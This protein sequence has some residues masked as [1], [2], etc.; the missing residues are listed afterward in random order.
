MIKLRGTYLEVSAR[1]FYKDL[2]RDAY[3]RVTLTDEED[4]PDAISKLRVIYP[5]LMRLDYDNR[6]TRGGAQ[7]LDAVDAERQSPLELFEDFYRQQNNGP[8]SDQQRAYLT[9]VMES[10]WEG[11]V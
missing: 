1:D 8:L 11:E 7:I 4:V 5:N 9:E 10:I 3:I 2:D 6:R